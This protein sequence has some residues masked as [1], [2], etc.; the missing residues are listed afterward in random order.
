[1]YELPLFAVA[2][3][4]V[5]LTGSFLGSLLSYGLDRVASHRE[6]QRAAREINYRAILGRSYGISEEDRVRP[7]RVTYRI[8][9][10]RARLQLI[11]A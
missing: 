6:A 7:V 1:M 11:E 9:D 5:L 8:K 10:V 4:A 2:T 3:A